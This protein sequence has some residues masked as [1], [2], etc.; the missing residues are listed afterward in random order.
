[1]AVTTH[2]HRSDE[3]GKDN[4]ANNKYRPLTTEKSTKYACVS[5]QKLLPAL[6]NCIS[7]QSL[8]RSDTQVPL[9]LIFL[10]CDHLLLLF[11]FLDIP[12]QSLLAIWQ[13][14]SLPLT[15]KRK[16]WTQLLKMDVQEKA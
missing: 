12:R 9:H 6:V 7:Q 5:T 3:V 13:Q 4:T 2:L 10:I 11:S 14:K 8:L 1:M 15:R 16:Y